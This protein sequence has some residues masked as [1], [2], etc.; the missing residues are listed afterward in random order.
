MTPTTPIGNIQK[1]VI[2][3]T[4]LTA[5]I[6]LALAFQFSDT[7]FYLNGFG[8]LALMA[9]LY[10]VPQLAPYRWFLRWGL[11]DYTL[12]TIVLFFVMNAG[13]TYGLLGLLT[14]AI[15]IGLVV[16]LLVESRQ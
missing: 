5:L 11:I 9:G 2:A 4:V 14:K 10:F 16:L 8:Y 12:L 13:G 3:L 7:L 6:H 1:G 15:E